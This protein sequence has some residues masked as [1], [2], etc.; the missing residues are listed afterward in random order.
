MVYMRFER[1]HTAVTTGCV[2][3]AAGPQLFRNVA[4][5]QIE[6]NSAAEQLGRNGC[7]TGINGVH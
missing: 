1:V 6:I 2:D 5:F 3:R 7:H 4:R